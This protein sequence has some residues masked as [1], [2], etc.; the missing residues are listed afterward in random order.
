MD[1]LFNGNY[2]WEKLDSINMESAEYIKKKSAKT[3]TMLK[4]LPYTS[5]TQVGQTSYEDATTSPNAR[6][7]NN[8]KIIEGLFVIFA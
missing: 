2:D 1:A 8:A 3:L 7:D 5:E 6:Q 4:A